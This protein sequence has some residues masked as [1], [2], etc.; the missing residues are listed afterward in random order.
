MQEEQ[1]V[2]SMAVISKVLG[3]KWGQLSPQEK[4][5]YYNRA[6]RDKQ[7]YI[8][9]M[10]AYFSHC[11]KGTSMQQLKGVITNLVGTPLHLYIGTR[12][13]LVDV[14]YRCIA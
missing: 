6:Q 12:N 9:E 3:Q 13:G 14:S 2:S 4:E 10:R 8:S 11:Y 7:R 1:G 5:Q